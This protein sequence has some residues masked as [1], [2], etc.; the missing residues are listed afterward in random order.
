MRLLVTGGS[1][2]LGRYLLPAAA[3]QFK[4]IAA[5]HAAP[6]AGGESVFLDLTNPA[7]VQRTIQ[8]IRP[9]AIIHAAA[10]NP[11]QSDEATMWRV[12]ADGSRWLAQA[13]AQIGARLV[14]VS[15][16]VVHNGQHAPYADAAP[17][18]P[19]NAYGRSKAAAEAAVL[20]ECPT[21]VIV[22][23]SL[24]YGLEHMDR[25]TEGFAKRLA[26]GEKLLLFSDVIRQPVWA[27]S[28]AAALL[29]LVNLDFSGTL[30]VAGRQAL[31]RE[32]FGRKMLAWWGIEAAG[33]I[34]V[35]LAAEIAPTTPLDLRLNV[36]QAEALLHM[37]LPGV[38]EVLAAHSRR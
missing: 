24:I 5:A 14:H 19:L 11:G 23:T 25:G 35:G 22:R 31:T 18:A 9:A 8:K 15:T 30:N 36:A 1:G 26:A 4:L 21:A 28:L 13:A 17:P 29:K 12:N 34:G 33:Q 16:D 6:V 20:A 27:H 3:A 32:E 2:Y 38:D 37:R 10:I 7:E